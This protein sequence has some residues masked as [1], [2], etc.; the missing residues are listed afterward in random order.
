M[1][2]STALAT[3][4]TTMVPLAAYADGFSSPYS[5]PVVRPQYPFT[6]QPYAAPNMNERSAARPAMVA[7]DQFGNTFTTSDQ[8]GM[9]GGAGGPLILARNGDLTYA[10]LI[11]GFDSDDVRGL[12]IYAMIHDYLPN[13]ERGPLDGARINGQVQFSRDDASIV[14]TQ[15]ILPNGLEIPIQAVAVSDEDGRTGVA[16]NV[17]RHVLSRY[18]S[19]F[20]AGLIQ[21]YGEVA[22]FRLQNRDSGGSTIIV[23]DGSTV[24]IQ[25]NGEPTDGEILAGAV[26]P[27]GNNLANVAAQNFNRPFTISAPAGMGLA[28]VFLQTVVTQPSDVTGRAFNPRSGQFEAVRLTNDIPANPAMSQGQMQQGS[29]MTNDPWLSIQDAVTATEQGQ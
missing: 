15:A 23:G 17:N 29:A 28:L 11:Y 7:T 26:R 21:G 5:D 12:P 2:L 14:F 13:G 8:S 9:L 25:D 1:K 16:Q 3:V 20:L 6:T 22:Q 19:L 4:L 27:I 18:G 10:T 24:T